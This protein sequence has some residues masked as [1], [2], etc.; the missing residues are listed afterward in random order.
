MLRADSITYDHATDIVTAE[1]NVE[2]T[3]GDNDEHIL[4]SHAIYN[5]R[6]QTGRFFEV[7][8]S[9]GLVRA[10]A[11][12]TFKATN[13]GIATPN[14]SSRTPSYQTSNPFVFEGRLVL[15]TGPT[16]YTIYDGSV[17]SCLL[18]HPDWQLYAGRIALN[19][20]KAKAS[21]STFKLLGL[22]VFS[23]PT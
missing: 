16:D 8:G 4:A 9:V 17:T 2:L 11:E 21:K 15:K 10:A 3:G 5:L 22:P 23:S 19:S 13:A 7:H 6:T 1:G 20:G 18:P 14:N 12:P